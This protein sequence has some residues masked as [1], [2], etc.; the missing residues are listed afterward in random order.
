MDRPGN[1]LKREGPV[2]DISVLLD[3]EVFRILREAEKAEPFRQF[4]DRA[5]LG[6][7]G[8]APL[9]HLLSGPD[10]GLGVPA[11][12]AEIDRNAESP[13][14]DP[15]G[16]FQDIQVQSP[17]FLSEMPDRF[18]RRY[19]FVLI[20]GVSLIGVLQYDFMIQEEIF[21]LLK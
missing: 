3:H 14:V 18:L 12:H 15:D 13:V 17:E 9:P 10:D 11:A 7:G 2:P 8:R 4:H 1:Q 19:D 5:R 21:S 20:Q 16:L 6:L